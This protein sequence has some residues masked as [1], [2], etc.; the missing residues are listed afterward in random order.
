MYNSRADSLFYKLY[1]LFYDVLVGFAVVVARPFNP[2]SRNSDENEI[3]L[4]VIAPCSNIQATRTKRGITK[5]KMSWY[6]DKFS[7][8]VP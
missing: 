5:D 3:S 7:L 8:L 6:L 2:L 1:L 4:Y